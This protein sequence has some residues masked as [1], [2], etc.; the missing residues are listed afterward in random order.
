MKNERQLLKEIIRD[1]HTHQVRSRAICE[2]AL[3]G[4]D[5][6]EWANANGLQT[7]YDNDGQLIIYL[8]DAFAQSNEL[9][10]GAH[11]DVQ[12]TYDDSG[13]VVYTGAGV[14]M[15]SE[16]EEISSGGLDD[17]DDIGIDFRGY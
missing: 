4:P 8:D 5:P 6:E 9:P 1:N 12:R 14:E 3:A 16:F 13:W 15:G 11:W 7:E 10:D 2:S 17:L